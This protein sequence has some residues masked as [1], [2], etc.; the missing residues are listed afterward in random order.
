MA[1]EGLPAT[2]EWDK[3]LVERPNIEEF[4]VKRYLAGVSRATGDGRNHLHQL[5]TRWASSSVK[6][7][8]GGMLSNVKENARASES[9]F[10]LVIKAARSGLVAA[11]SA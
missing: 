3:C 11:A 1:S 9:A 6:S 10:K 4:D 5:P 7:Q 8:P 2:A